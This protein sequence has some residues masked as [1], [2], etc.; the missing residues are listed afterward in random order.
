MV[1][2]GDLICH[3]LSL[4][5]VVVISIGTLSTEQTPV[6]SPQLLSSSTQQQPQHPLHN[7]A[8]SRHHGYRRKN[9]SPGNSSGSEET[10]RVSDQIKLNS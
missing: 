7:S 6:V 9:Q 2:K 4:S 1:F 8:T 10:I 3:L 5:D